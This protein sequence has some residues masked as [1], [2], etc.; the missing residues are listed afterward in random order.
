MANDDGNGRPTAYAIQSRGH[1]WWDDELAPDR[2]HLPLS[3]VAGELKITQEGGA[4]VQLD[5]TLPRQPREPF[6]ITGPADFETLR[7]RRIRGVLRGSGRGVLLLDLGT[8][9]AVHSS[10][11]IS[12]EGFSAA[13]CLISESQFD[14]RL[15]LP[16]F[17]RIDADL[18]G[19]EDWLWSR[20]LHIKYGRR[21]STAR[22][23]SPK[24]ITY[25]LQIGRLS[26]EQHLIASSQAH[27]DITWNE[28]A[29]L[30]FQPDKPLGIE[31]ISE[32]HRWLQDFMILLTDSDYCLEWPRVRWGKHDCTLYF[33]RVG[34]TTAERPQLHE[35]AT[36]F[37]KISESFG[38][39]FEKWL[40]VRNTYG[41]GV[42]SYLSTRRGRQ[43]YT[44]NQFITL[45]SGLESFHRTKYGDIPSQRATAKLEKIVNQIGNEKDKMW[46]ANRLSYTTL[47]NLENRIFEAIEALSLG[48]DQKRLR[49]FAEDCAKLRNDL[50]HY[51]GSRNKTTGYS[52]F[53]T[54]VMKKN[55]ALG[56]LCH[57]LALTEIGLDPATV[58]T[59]AVDGPP[60]FRRRWY[61]AEVG[62]IDYADPKLALKSRCNEILKP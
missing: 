14:G 39:L 10:Y 55:N 18:K 37:P 33:R 11:A 44:E 35:C 40:A 59:W 58:R 53:V 47:P 61:F 31:A 15:K 24:R 49:A 60:A 32:W 48:L 30:R 27:T 23:R 8:A 16:A 3:A 54:S 45:I 34:S 52:E 22:Y 41:P 28:K 6:Y 57:A 26:L 20:A 38:A 17:K 7:R 1:F 42:Y 25:Q 56:P 29:Y 50:A 36:S 9:G 43:S 46:V 4:T 13:Q 21:L 62:L 12:T 5:A 2:H 51:G 19:F